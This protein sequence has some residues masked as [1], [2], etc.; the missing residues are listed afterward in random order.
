MATLVVDLVTDLGTYE[1]AR[2]K[3]QH[4]KYLRQNVE[5]IIDINREYNSLSQI[6]ISAFSQMTSMSRQAEYWT[7]IYWFRS[8]GLPH[9]WLAPYACH[10]MDDNHPESR[11]KPVYNA[12]VDMSEQ[13]LHRIFVQEIIDHEKLKIVEES[14]LDANSVDNQN[15]KKE[16]ETH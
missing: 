8:I 12:N 7:A 1:L 13:T 11:G 6:D 4:P 15:N 14:P 3:L 2:H 16:A 9:M 5:N 10:I